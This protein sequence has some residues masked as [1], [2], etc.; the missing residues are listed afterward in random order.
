M[1]AAAVV[2][3]LVLTDIS[4][5]TLASNTRHFTGQFPPHTTV[6]RRIPGNHQGVGY[7]TDR[8]G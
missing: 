2:D 8:K 6:S 4:V 5:D 1:V 7:S 3:I